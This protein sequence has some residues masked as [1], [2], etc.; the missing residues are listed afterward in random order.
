MRLHKMLVLILVFGLA[1][2]IMPIGVVL[3]EGTDIIKSYSIEISPQSDGSLINT[4][5]LDW[6]VISD[7]AGPLSWFYVGMPN[8]HF[9]IL[10]FNGN[11]AYVEPENDG[12]EYRMR[13]DLDQ[14]ANAGEC[15]AV[16]VRVHQL[17]L[18]YLDEEAGEISYQF[19][20]GWFD[21]IPV[22]L[23][24]LTWQLL[25]EDAT[26]LQ[27][28]NPQPLSQDDAQAI[29]ETSLQPG[30]KFTVDAIYD[31]TAFPDFTPDQRSSILKDVPGSDQ[32]SRPAA[33]SESEGMSPV[34]N[35]SS[36]R[37][38]LPILM[39][40]CSCVFIVLLIIFL[41]VLLVIVNNVRK[42]FRRG[43][44]FG[45]YRRYRESQDRGGGIYRIPIPPRGGS[46]R[47]TKRSGGGSGKFGGRGSSCACVSSG[48]A[49]ACAGGGRAGCS[50]KGFDVSELIRAKAR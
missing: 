46:S 24:R 39:S 6:C 21:D 1:F 5:S 18:A 38:P 11:A 2:A 8:E 14:E 4:Y 43:G 37:S 31:Q 15:V 26:L 12:F 25:V 30:E 28:F 33:A 19:T 34:Q 32:S 44:Y 20:P 47:T 48:C 13:I 50:R 36:S 7:A 29:W 3:A 16:S 9:Q 49:C 10:S 22:E 41:I 35:P 45:N 17:N 27:S 23:L 42:S 40:T